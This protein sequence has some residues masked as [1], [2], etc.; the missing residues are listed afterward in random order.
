MKKSILSIFIILIFTNIAWSDKLEDIKKN[1][2]L[3]AGVYY[4]FEPFSFHDEN[5]KPLGFEIDMLKYFAEKLNVDL[6]IVHVT[7]KNRFEMLLNNQ[8][9]ILPYVN[10]Q[11][12]I[13]GIEKTK[14]YIDLKQSFLV[15][16]HSKF[17]NIFHLKGK[18]VAYF[19]E[20]N[21]EF[22]K[23]N[24]SKARPVQ[25]FDLNEAV[26]DLL[27]GKIDALT[28]NR[29]WCETQKQKN[30]SKLQFTDFYF[31]DIFYSYGIVFNETNFLNKINSLID[32]SIKDGTFD[33]LY[34]KW[35]L[36]K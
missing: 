30:I 10:S 27:I 16:K 21:I 34:E 36:E 5:F 12:P 17:S 29:I 19:D 22:I 28:E 31:N 32:Q 1:N 26:E 25:Y 14:S 20:N 8:I 9:D 3:K 6:K 2:I 35:F 33:E 18:T 23:Q 11:K 7:P 4:D 13:L 24:I 15:L